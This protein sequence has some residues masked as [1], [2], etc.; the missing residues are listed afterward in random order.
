MEPMELGTAML[1]RDAR[2]SGNLSSNTRWMIAGRHVLEEVASRCLET[3][4]L[5]LSVRT[6]AGSQGQHIC[7]RRAVECA[8]QGDP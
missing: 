8:F 3:P 2:L 6:L 1:L 5:V 4:S 7:R